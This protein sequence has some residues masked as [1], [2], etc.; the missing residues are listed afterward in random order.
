MVTTQDIISGNWSQPIYFDQT[1]IDPDLFFD[2]DGCVYLST[3]LPEFGPL[4]GNSTIWQSRVDVTTG[5][6]LTQPALIYRSSLPLKIRWAEGPHVYKINGTYYLSV[7][8]GKLDLTVP[9]VGYDQRKGGTEVLHRQTIRRGPY[10]SGPWE[11]SPLGPVVFN[12]RNPSAPIQQTGHA[13]LVVRPDGRWYAVFLAVRPQNPSNI[14]GT[15]II[16]RETFLSP[17]T[18]SKDGW[19]LANNG[20]EITFEMADPYLPAQPIR[21]TTWRFLHP[22]LQLGVP[23]YTLWR[24]VPCVQLISNLKRNAANSRGTRRHGIC[25]P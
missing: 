9:C 10:P 8:E 14:N 13:D 18:W 21:N 7:A 16:G 22:R 24:L 6:S 19:P 3:G 11:S 4:G 23:R 1:G 15:W 20:S 25:G 2:D 12:G 17:V 5:E